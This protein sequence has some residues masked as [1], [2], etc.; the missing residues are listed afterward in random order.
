MRTS[1]RPRV[2][3]FA[4]IGS[5]ATTCARTSAKPLPSH[6][7]FTCA[8]A[9]ACSS[10]LRRRPQHCTCR[11]RARAV[12]AGDLTLRPAPARVERLHLHLYLRLRRPLAL[13]LRPLPWAIHNR[14]VP[15]PASTPQA[16]RAASRHRITAEISTVPLQQ[17]PAC[18][19]SQKEAHQLHLGETT[20]R[21]PRGRSAA[22]RRVAL[23]HVKRPTTRRSHSVPV[24][25]T[26]TA[27]TG[28]GRG[29]RC[30]T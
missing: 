18:L 11:A 16:S 8:C 23:F 19:N 7:I 4:P 2:S 13:C 24:Q 3:P 20:V 17:E 29:G 6:C 14:H 12:C 26:S 15:A 22:R 10:R 28:K 21:I 5:H 27:P 30:F 9:C 1:A 25:P